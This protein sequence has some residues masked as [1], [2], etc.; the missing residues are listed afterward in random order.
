MEIGQRGVLYEDNPDLGDKRQALSVGEAY[1]IIL[2]IGIISSFRPVVVQTV[3]PL[4]R[5]Q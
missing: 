1:W 3:L 5:P 2:V 4:E